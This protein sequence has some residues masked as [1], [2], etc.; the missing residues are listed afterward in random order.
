MENLISMILSFTTRELFYTGG[1]NWG[2]LYQHLNVDRFQ[3]M[4][5]ASANNIT[6]ISNPQTLYYGINDKIVEE[7]DQK[8]I[9]A[10]KRNKIT[11]MWRSYGLT[12]FTNKLH[13]CLDT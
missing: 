1:G 2:S 11:F 8:I 7:N 13:L 4:R 3:Y 10:F 12:F 9:K 6:V 5:V